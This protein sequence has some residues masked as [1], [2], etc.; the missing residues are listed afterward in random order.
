MPFWD[1]SHSVARRTAR[2]GHPTQHV[3]N[4]TI[5]DHLPWQRASRVKKKNNIDNI[6]EAINLHANPKILQ[7]K[8]AEATEPKLTFKEISNIKRQSL[9]SQLSLYLIKTTALKVY[10]IR[11]NIC[12]IYFKFP[13]MILVD[14]TY[15]LLDWQMTVYLLFCIVGDGLSKIVATFTLVCRSLKSTALPGLRV[16]MYG[17]ISLHAM[18][19]QVV[20]SLS[21]NL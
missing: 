9:T 19:L 6:T 13:K 11:I 17:K 14:A 7:Q 15:K 20:R 2:R 16:T 3:A 18:L 8:V 12:R 10:S 5:Y 1:L 21:A 4:K